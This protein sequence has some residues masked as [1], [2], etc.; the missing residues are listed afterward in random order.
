MKNNKKIINKQEIN[1]TIKK[2]K[3]RRKTESYLA[4]NLSYGKMQKK[5]HQQKLEQNITNDNN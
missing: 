3:N 4:E 1:Q 2:K 5:E